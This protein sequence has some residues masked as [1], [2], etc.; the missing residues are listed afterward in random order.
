M[1]E[2][3]GQLARLVGQLT[4]LPAAAPTASLR[5]ELLVQLLG[6]MTKQAEV[7]TER[8][9]QPW[10]RKRDAYAIQ[11][12]SDDAKTDADLRARYWELVTTSPGSLSAEET[13]RV[14]YA[15]YAPT[16]PP[17]L[18]PAAQAIWAADIAA[19][20]RRYASLI[21]NASPIAAMRQHNWWVLE[22]LELRHPGRMTV[23]GHLIDG[24]Q[25]VL[26]PA[27]SDFDSKNELLLQAAEEVRGGGGPTLDHVVPGRLT[28]TRRAT[29]AAQPVTGGA[30]WMPVVTDPATG[31]AY[32]DLQPVADGMQMGQDR[33]DKKVADLER[34]I[35]ELKARPQPAPTATLSADQLRKLAALTALQRGK[36]GDAGK[37]RAEKAIAATRGF[38]VDEAKAYIGGRQPR[39]SRPPRNAGKGPRGGGGDGDKDPALPD[40]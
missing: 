4:V 3:V 8:V 9:D 10:R 30:V 23:S 1:A 15:E 20:P 16:V 34:Q 26:Y 33:V 19:L 21:S 37:E 36:G 14:A 27:H 40:F 13:V 12:R 7:T 5:D 17:G 29:A 11:R 32:V 28:T 25:T 38:S 35:Q 24:L 2:L 6:K 18:D 31:N 39:T 22:W